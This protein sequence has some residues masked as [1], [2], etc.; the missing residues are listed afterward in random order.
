M[1]DFEFSL[2]AQGGPMMLVL[3]VMAVAAVVLFAE[4]TLYLHR[5]QIRSTAFVDGIKNILEKRRVME[6]LTV[7]EETPG[8]VAAV[9]KSAL[10]HV[11]DDEAKMRFAVQEA[12]IVEIP[13]LERRLGSIA[14]I[15][16]IAPLVGLLG[17]ALGM[18]T[19]FYA[20]M[21][22]GA[23]YA[24]ARA[25][26]DGMWQALLVTI[27]SL[28]LAIPAHLGYHF[29]SG[30]VRAIVRDVEWAGNEIM[31][32]LLVDY[33]RGVLADQGR[34]A[35]VVERRQPAAESDPLKEEGESS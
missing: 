13:A 11:H 3:L 18:A 10:L 15:A 30:R 16:Q 6:A 33:R 23:E 19:T 25:L 4:R 35:G 7:C 20:F 8:P 32:Y 24:T 21:S 2:L 28:T 1:G 17:T 27:G 12:G 31:R 26:A 34:E 22:G 14:A 9:V 29:L 5:G